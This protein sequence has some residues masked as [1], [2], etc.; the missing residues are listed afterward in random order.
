MGAALVGNNFWPIPSEFHFPMKKEYV[1]SARYLQS[2]KTFFTVKLSQYSKSGSTFSSSEPVAATAADSETPSPVCARARP[3]ELGHWFCSQDLQSPGDRQGLK[4]GLKLALCCLTN[5]LLRFYLLW[6]PR[7]NCVE[8]EFILGPLKTPKL[9]KSGE[10]I[11]TLIHQTGV[12]WCVNK[13]IDKYV[14]NDALNGNN[15]KYSIKCV[16]SK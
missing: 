7:I 16:I 6:N 9:R 8:F 2:I 13:Y 1:V 4:L 12:K 14:T 5:G 10:L 15:L 3:Q 11:S